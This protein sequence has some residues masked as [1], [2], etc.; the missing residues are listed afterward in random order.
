LGLNVPSSS[1]PFLIGF[2]A[3]F[4]AACSVLKTLISSNPFL[5]AI[6]L[7]GVSLTFFGGGV[8]EDSRSDSRCDN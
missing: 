8:T 4:L 2:V 1:P 5:A 7:F 3:A 6:E